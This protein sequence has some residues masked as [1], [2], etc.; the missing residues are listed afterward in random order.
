[1]GARVIS[2]VSI[3]VCICFMSMVFSGCWYDSDS[4]EFDDPGPEVDLFDFRGAHHDDDLPNIGQENLVS[5]DFINVIES[6]NYGADWDCNDSCGCDCM[7]D[8]LKLLELAA[9]YSD[10]ITLE[11]LERQIEAIESGEVREYQPP[12]SPF[13]LKYK[14]TEILNIGFLVDGLDR[15]PLEVITISR[16]ESEDYYERK[17]LFRDPWVGTFKGIL[18]T[19]KGNGPFPGIIANHGHCD[20]AEG[21]MFEYRG[22]EFPSHGYAILMLTSRVFCTTIEEGSITR[23][24]L[25]DGFT[26]LGIRHYETLLGLKYMRYL[27][28]VDNGSI[29]LIGH[30][31]GSVHGNVKVCIEDQFKAYVS[32]CESDYLGG[33]EDHMLD[34]FC[35]ELWPYHKLINSFKGALVPVLQVPY[36]YANGMDEIFEFFDGHLK[37]EQE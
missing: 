4:V 6:E 10:P 33:H 29:G 17:L 1:M 30:S 8:Y 12:L 27:S 15:R 2:S 26:M 23:A 11:E 16:H 24:M 20:N 22:S 21:Y 19:P 34:D 14:L 35:P 5:R 13:E 18:L 32:D 37:K 9:D 3:G 36:G 7:D 25:L 31:G 28:Q